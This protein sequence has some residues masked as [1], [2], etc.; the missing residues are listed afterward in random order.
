MNF[1]SDLPGIDKIANRKLIGKIF[2]QSLCINDQIVVKETAVGR[3]HGHLFAARPHHIGVT[4]ADVRHVVDAVQI[5]VAL[6]IIHVLTLSSHDLQR[7]L[8]EEKG[9]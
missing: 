3:N 2:G 7:T 9:H 8:F 1:G 4:V 5:A 6:F